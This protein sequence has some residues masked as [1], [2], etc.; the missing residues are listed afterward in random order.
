MSRAAVLEYLLTIASSGFEDWRRANK[1][2]D[3]FDF[4][5]KLNKM[6]QSGALFDMDKLL[7][8]S[9]NYISRMST[10]DVLSSLLSWAEKYDEA[11]YNRLSGDKAYAA[12]I[13]SIDR[14][15][16]KPRKDIAKWNEAAP[17]YIIFLRRHFCP[18]V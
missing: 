3:I 5:L 2:A 10:E 4:D 13:F 14:D 6:S 9:K 18:A 8:V 1:D 15:I 11:L 7:D 16:P 17:V 12:A